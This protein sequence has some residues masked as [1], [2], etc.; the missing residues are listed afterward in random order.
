M[1]FAEPLENLVDFNGEL[2][3]DLMELFSN[4]DIN[5]TLWNLTDNFTFED[6][7]DEIPFKTEKKG[8]QYISTDFSLLIY[9]YYYGM[10][11]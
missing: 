3:G 5:K 2:D 6:F 8:P 9:F 11:E 1:E 10:G 4:M 7:F